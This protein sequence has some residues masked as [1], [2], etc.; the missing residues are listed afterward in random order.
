MLIEKGRV[1]MEGDPATVVA[2]HQEHM[3]A[4]R[5]AKIAAAEAAG[6]DPRIVKTR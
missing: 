1:I 4:A 2:L 5:A 6:V 3:E